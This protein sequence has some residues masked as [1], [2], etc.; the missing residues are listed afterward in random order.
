MRRREGRARQRGQTGPR[1]TLVALY[2]TEAFADPESGAS[3]PV[4]T[5][6]P[7][8]A[9]DR[10]VRRLRETDVGRVNHPILDRQLDHDV[11]GAVPWMTFDGRSDVAAAQLRRYAGEVPRPSDDVPFPTVVEARRQLAAVLR[12]WAYY[13]RRDN[14]WRDMLPYTSVGLLEAVINA[15]TDGDRAKA[16]DDLRDRVVEAVSVAEGVRNPCCAASTWR[17]GSP[18][19]AT[20]R[21]A[22]TACSRRTSSV[23]RSRGPRTRTSSSSRPTPWN[24][25]R[26]SDQRGCE[27]RSTS[28]R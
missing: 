6:G 28:W 8:R 16:C 7:E 27:S 11:D 4:H 13:E 18:G 15:S 5:A 12:R 14:G 3:L 26:S 20:L 22:R 21:S 17:C 24:W 23:S 10:L 1:A 9:V 2:Y 25:F 19:S